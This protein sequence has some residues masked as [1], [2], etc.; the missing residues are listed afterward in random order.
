[1]TLSEARSPNG[2]GRSD[3]LGAF[4]R[5]RRGKVSLKQA[6][7]PGRRGGRAATLTQE[8]LARLT[9]YSIRTISGLE[10]GTDHRPTPD[11]LE[12]IAAALR[13]STAERH[14]LWYLATKAPPP[15]ESYLSGLDP[16]MARLVR[17]VDPQ[18][19]MAYDL[20]WDIQ[21][22][23]GAMAAWACDWSRRSP[24]QR[25]FARWLLLDPHARHVHVDWEQHLAPAF[26]GRMRMLAAQM[27][28]HPTLTGL[29][30]EICDRSPEVKRMW[31]SST[32]VYSHPPSI[33]R[34][35]RPPGHTDPRQAD[36]E[37]HHVPVT[38]CVLSPT[39]PDDE[40]R[41]IAYLLPEDYPYDPAVIS[42]EACTACA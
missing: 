21:T 1:M 33:V 34:P 23:N 16:G 10:Q 32:E 14:T 28:Q 22:Y 29:I 39:K 27:P 3:R 2:A 7:L 36:D 9:G 13:L 11:L 18:P 40:R 41:L 30:D 35:F 8:D 24:E 31:D 25:N 4:L 37:T 26:V 12:A 6:G 17:L 42:S 5:D 15:E 20:F 38:M 19:A